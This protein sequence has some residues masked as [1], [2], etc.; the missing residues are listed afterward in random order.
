M[1]NPFWTMK[2]WKLITAFV[3]LFLLFLSVVSYV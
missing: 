2:Q 3:G 1:E